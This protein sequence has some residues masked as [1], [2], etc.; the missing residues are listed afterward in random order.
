[1]P[2]NN[3]RSFRYQSVFMVQT[4]ETRASHDFEVAWNAMA[5]L[6]RRD[7][8]IGCGVRDSWARAGMGPASSVMRDPL[9]QNVA[10]LLL[11]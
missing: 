5:M 8:E 10:Q 4:A 7:G 9:F 1:V 11:C 3:S 6:V 2:R